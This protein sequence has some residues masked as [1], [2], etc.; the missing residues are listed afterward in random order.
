[1]NSIDPQ[2]V[3]KEVSD[4]AEKDLDLLFA[5]VDLGERYNSADDRVWGKLIK[6]KYDRQTARNFTSKPSSHLWKVYCLHSSPKHSSQ[7][8]VSSLKRSWRC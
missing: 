5:L 7:T 1:M 3:P 4:L 8:L 6:E 2:S